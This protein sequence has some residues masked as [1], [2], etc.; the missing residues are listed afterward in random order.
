VKKNVA[1]FALALNQV[2]T[3]KRIF[4]AAKKN[5]ELEL[6]IYDQIGGGYWSEGVTAESVKKALNDAGDVKTIKVRINSPGGDVFEGSAIYSLLVQ[7]K[8]TVEVYVDGLAASAAFT[9]AMAGDKI[10][11]SEAGMM[12]LHNAWGMAIGESKDMRQ[13]ADL[14][15][16]VSGTMRDIYA[17]KCGK[18]ADEVQALMDAETWMTAQEAVDMGFADDVI[19]R[20]AGD[21]AEA[22]ALA[23]SFDMKKF[24][25]KPPAATTPTGVNAQPPTNA[26]KEDDDEDEEDPEQS[27]SMECECDC[28]ACKAGDCE[29]C[30]NAECDDD[31]C[32]ED[33]CPN[34]KAAAEKTKNFADTMQ[35]AFDN[36]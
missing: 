25:K 24:A 35:V 16:K 8:A 19:K 21:D 18:S 23:A 31:E 27:A 1:L 5:E 11:C 33:G 14:L 26:K 32:E 29:G 20:D 36:L 13:T 30:T 17:G 4:A 6:L 2:Q 15:D 12:M 3:P 28:A 34:Q 9:I 22:K 10:H 7:H